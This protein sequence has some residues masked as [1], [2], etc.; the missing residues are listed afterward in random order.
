GDILVL[1]DFTNGGSIGTIQVCTWAGGDGTAGHLECQESSVV[2][3][4]NGVFCTPG[5]IACATINQGPVPAFGAH[6]PKSP[7]PNVYALGAFFE[8]GINATELLGD[9]PCF[10]SFLVETRSSQSVSATL[11]D[12]VLGDLQVC[13]PSVELCKQCNVAL[14]TVGDNV[15]LEVQY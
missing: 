13:A 7:A 14:Q 5:D 8:G 12:F 3:A 10:A 11:K 4:G 15:V 6:T 9:T 2:S 1:S